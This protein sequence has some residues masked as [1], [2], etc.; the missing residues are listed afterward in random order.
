MDEFVLVRF[1]WGGSFLND[2]IELTYVGASEGISS[3]EV[4]KIGLPE[5]RGHLRDHFPDYTEDML[6]H[7]C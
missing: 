6:M 1:H 3:I 5:V 4:D 7:W 2:G